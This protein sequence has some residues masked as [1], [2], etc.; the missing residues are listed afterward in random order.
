MLQNSNTSITPNRY[1]RL[2]ALAITEIIWQIILTVF[3]M[4]DNISPGLRPWT[5]WA[6]V[7]SD[8]L[9]VDQYYLAEFLPAYKNQMFLFFFAIPA[10][11]LLFFIFFGFGEQAVS[12]YRA[13]FDWVRRKVFRQ[14][15]SAQKIPKNGMMLRYAHPTF[16]HLRVSSRIASAYSSAGNVSARSAY[17]IPNFVVAGDGNSLP[18]Y[19]P[20]SDRAVFHPSIK[21]ESKKE[22]DDFDFSDSSLHNV[23]IA[24]LSSGE[25]SPTDTESSA[26]SHFPAA[27]R[28]ADEHF[29]GAPIVASQNALE[30]PTGA[31]PGGLPVPPRAAA[32]VSRFSRDSDIADMA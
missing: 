32:Q 17:S 1:L 5:T 22:L 24:T 8:W 31:R 7:H 21:S 19:S 13:L 18:A 27:S 20:P 9:R 30:S 3:P 2:M 14:K 6:D 12:D 28:E 29:V 26:G 15:P 4:Y 16:L 11:S 10:S 25:Y 23:A